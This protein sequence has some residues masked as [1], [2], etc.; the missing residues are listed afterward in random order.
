MMIS[1]ANFKDLEI[2]LQKDWSVDQFSAVLQQF[3]EQV[4]LILSFC[5]IAGIPVGKIAKKTV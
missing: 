2:S 3:T 1:T 5:Q 4:C